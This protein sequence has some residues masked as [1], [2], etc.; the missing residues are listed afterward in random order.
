MMPGEFNLRQF[1]AILPIYIVVG[2]IILSEYSLVSGVIIAVVL[3]AL[4]IAL[5]AN[6]NVW[7]G[8]AYRL[9]ERGFI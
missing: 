3:A 6:S 1:L 5:L 2:L 4:S 8:I 7:R 9:T